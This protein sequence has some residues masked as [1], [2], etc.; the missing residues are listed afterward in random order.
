MVPAVAQ[1]SGMRPDE[2]SVQR[3]FSLSMT[4]TSLTSSYIGRS[5]YGLEIKNGF[6]GRGIRGRRL[7][8]LLTAIMLLLDRRP[9]GRQSGSTN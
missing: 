2:A 3:T 5:T 8:D 7:G 6:L 1:K 4:G 9:L